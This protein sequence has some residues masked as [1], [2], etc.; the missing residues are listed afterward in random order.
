ME[1]M[2]RS[3]DNLAELVPSFLLS[4][5][6]RIRPLAM[7]GKC[8]HSLNHLSGTGKVLS[9]L[10]LAALLL[11]KKKSQICKNFLH[12]YLLLLN[13]DVIYY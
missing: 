6:P 1:V 11:K 12:L 4:V 5:G 2:W 8:L 3:E 9:Q 10:L 7:A 13:L